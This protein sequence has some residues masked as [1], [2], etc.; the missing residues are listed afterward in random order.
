M[1]AKRLTSFSSLIALLGLAV[2]L[3]H[4]SSDDDT[5]NTGGTGGTAGTAGSVSTGGKGGSAGSAGSAGSSAGKG[6]TAAGGNSA[7]GAAGDENG[8]AGE[9][10]AAGA[11]STGKAKLSSLKH[12]VIIY[13][14]N[15][16]FD[17]LYGSYPGAEGLASAGAAIAQVDHAT[18][19]AFTTLPQKDP[20]V[21]LSLPNQAFDITKYVA[22]NQKT[23]DLVH[24]YYQEQV[25]I[26]GGKMDQFV[27][28]SDAQG[29]SFGFYPTDELPVVKLMKTIPTQVTLLD[30]FFHAGFGG[31]FLNHHWL[32]AAATPT[33]TSPPVSMVSV[34]GPDG[35]PTTDAQ[36]AA[37]GTHVVNTSY[38]INN[39]H[40]SAYDPAKLVPNL[41][42]P[43]IGDRLTAAGVDWAWYSGGWDDALAGKPDPL[44]QFHHQPF[45]YYAN[46]ADGTPAKAA[47]LKD[48]TVFLTAA[49]AGT[50][51]PV[52]FVKPLGANNEHPGYAD[53]ATGESHTV[54]LINA[55][56]NGPDWADTAIIITYDEHGGFFDHVAPP[57]PDKDYARADIWGPGARVP[58]IVISPFA[59]GGV[60]KTSYDTTAILKLIEKR[61]NVA[62]L[63]SR[64]AAQND[65]S[66]NAFD[67]QP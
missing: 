43:T 51:P 35:L 9:A 10:G 64:D 7:A 65:L 31:S 21:P 56:M 27:S 61:W 54:D 59:K 5:V 57:T 45:A 11:A 67:F 39:P 6:G 40:P 63:G 28:V 36:I 24:R 13:L 34:L 1:N 49:A 23:I 33:F 41:T 15:H 42:N 2:L 14:E 29:L 38:T 37:D 66:V 60:D 55:V 52:S 50:L 53:L 25:Q 8:S 62:S 46:Y 3:P 19:T 12:L 17:N 44:F 32:I 47:H 26:D 16:S 30:H 22:Q 48:E 18:K 4:C 20:N 58:G